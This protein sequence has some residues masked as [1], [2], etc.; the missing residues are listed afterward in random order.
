MPP[1]RGRFGEFDTGA[2]WELV[3]EGTEAGAAH[4]A[5]DADRAGRSPEPADVELLAVDL[6]VPLSHLQN[7]V[8]GRSSKP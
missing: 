3:S 6:A 7:R 2:G 5:L 8:L 4:D 1:S